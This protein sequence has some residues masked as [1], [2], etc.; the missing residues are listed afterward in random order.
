MEQFLKSKK[1]HLINNNS[2]KYIFMFIVERDEILHQKHHNFGQN[3][4]IEF[5]MQISKKLHV[6]YGEAIVK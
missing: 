5:N 2:A 4:F 1:N 3:D 6:I